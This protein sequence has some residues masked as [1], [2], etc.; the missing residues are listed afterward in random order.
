MTSLLPSSL[1]SHTDIRLPSPICVGVGPVWFPSC[2]DRG[3][4][5]VGSGPPQSIQRGGWLLPH[6][7]HQCCQRSQGTHT[8]TG[9]ANATPTGNRPHPFCILVLCMYKLY[10][11]S[12]GEANYMYS[13]KNYLMWSLVVLVIWTSL[14]PYFMN[15]A[16]ASHDEQPPDW[17][18]GLL[19]RREHRTV[20]ICILPTNSAKHDSCRDM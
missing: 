10:I 1:H 12:Q 14:L 15:I 9:S 3:R 18:K 16:A 5:H 13:C 19:W 7:T 6:H 4:V 20:L 2:W 8:A 17:A 11:V